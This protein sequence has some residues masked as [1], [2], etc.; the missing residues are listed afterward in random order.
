MMRVNEIANNV[1]SSMRAHAPIVNGWYI[2]VGSRTVR[3][4]LVKLKTVKN[5][6]KHYNCLL[7]EDGV[8]DFNRFKVNFLCWIYC[9]I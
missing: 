2:K 6:T 7:F 9:V 1:A 5:H 4:E 3:S 8:N